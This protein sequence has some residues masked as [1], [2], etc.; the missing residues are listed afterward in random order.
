MNVRTRRAMQRAGV[1]ALALAVTGALASL[2]AP[3]YAAEGVDL[4]VTVDSSKIAIGSEVK[5]FFAKITNGGDTAAEGLKV[6]IDLSGVDASLVKVTVDFDGCTTAD[7]AISCAFD[8]KIAPGEKIDI[9]LLVTPVKG[10]EPKSAGVIKVTVEPVL[11]PKDA[12]PANNTAT[13][14]IELVGS[15]GDIVAIADDVVAGYGD[16]GEVQPVAPGET[17]SL[18]WAI[19]NVGDVTLSAPEFTIQLPKYASF[20]DKF[21]GCRYSNGDRSVTC[22]APDWTLA[23]NS[24]VGGGEEGWLVKVAADAPGPVTLSGTITG[25]AGGVVEKLRAA[26]TAAKPAWAA[27][28]KPE[29]EVDKGDNSDEFAVFIGAAGGSGGGDGGDGGLPITGARVGLIGGV[30]GA[31]V[32]I[33]VVLFVLARRRRVVLVTPDDEAPTV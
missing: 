11:D 15:G 31:V 27:E 33:G 18:Y 13:A 16:D 22:T 19:L 21:E 25:S 30:G 7:K 32:A 17:A 23:P 1:G 8:G 12:N 20:V 2:A 9:P 26:T 14:P 6:D 28:A 10:A 24:A 3:A 29:T 5:P 4:S